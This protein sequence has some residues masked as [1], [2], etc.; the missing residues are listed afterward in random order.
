MQIANRANLPDAI[1]QAVIND[2][3]DAGGCNIS[4]TGLIGPPRIRMLSRAHWD[5]LQEDASDRIWALVGRIG[6]GILE[7]AETCA[8]TGRKSAVKL[9]DSQN[10]AWQH[11]REIQNGYVEHRPGESVRCADY[12]PVARFCSQRQAQLAQREAE[13]A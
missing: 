13:A 8:E 5:K 6:H 3:Y 12:C 9:H 1:V 11:A 7:R 4:V 2:P 10:D